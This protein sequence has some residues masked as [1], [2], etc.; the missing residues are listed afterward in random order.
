[1]CQSK[2]KVRANSSDMLGKPALA[3]NLHDITT[4]LDHKDEDGSQRSRANVQ[5]PDTT[6]RVSGLGRLSC[7]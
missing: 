4:D 1:M 3:S 6:R 2:L 5:V 7:F